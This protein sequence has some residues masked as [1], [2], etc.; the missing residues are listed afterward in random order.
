VVTEVYLNEFVEPVNAPR[1]PN[2]IGQSEQSI[3]VDQLF[4][5]APM[6]ARQ[7]CNHPDVAISAR[8][9]LVTFP[10]ESNDQDS[11]TRSN[12]EFVTGTALQSPSERRESYAYD[13]GTH[14]LL[15]RLG[16]RRGSRLLSRCSVSSYATH[17][18]HA[19]RF[20]AIAHSEN[21]VLGHPPVILSS[22]FL[23]KEQKVFAS[24]QQ[25][26]S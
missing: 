26:N 3:L 24:F 7:V 15:K 6:L 21:D 10:R 9:V 12:L 17:E 5:R 20:V 8:I 2:R 11:S 23:G 16:L 1:T 18:Q 25:V 22:I 13:T 19:Q 4:Q 14:G